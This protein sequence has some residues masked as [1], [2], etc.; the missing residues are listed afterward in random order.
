MLP[1]DEATFCRATS[2]N[3]HNYSWN[4]MAYPI[5]ICVLVGLPGSGKSTFARHA[6]VSPFRKLVFSYDEVEIKDT[7]YKSFRRKARDRLEKLI[8]DETTEPTVIIVDD[9]MTFRSMRYEIFCLAR[10]HNLGFCQIYMDTTV[11]T[12]ILRNI[13]RGSTKITA[14]MIRDQSKR[15]EVPGSSNSFIDKF[16]MVVKDNRYD[17]DELLQL[18]QNAGHELPSSIDKRPSQPKDQSA[19]HKI[20]LILRKHI[21][22]CISQEASPEAKRILAQDMNSRRQELLQDIRNTNIIFNEPFDDVINYL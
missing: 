3:R 22:S 15:L 2:A 9:I 16:V 11:D 13:E 19:V 10:K 12:C 7:N 17:P 20:D 8:Q 5:V 1:D 4:C 21:G 18:I 6:I 14:E